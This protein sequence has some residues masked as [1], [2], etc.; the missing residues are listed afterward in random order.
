M[1]FKEQL[2]LAKQLCED[3]LGILYLTQDVDAEYH[4]YDPDVETIFLKENPKTVV[5]IEFH[6][7]KDLRDRIQREINKRWTLGIIIEEVPDI[8]TPEELKELEESL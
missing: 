5:R 1:T 3:A 7:I 4:H 2:T 6:M 8:L